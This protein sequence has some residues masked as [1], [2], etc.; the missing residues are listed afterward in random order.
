MVAPA[1]RISKYQP[2][3]ICSQQ[4]TRQQTWSLRFIC[5][6]SS[7]EK[8]VNLT[9]FR[10]LPKQNSP[11]RCL[12][13]ESWEAQVNVCTHLG[14]LITNSDYKWL[15]AL[16]QQPSS[17]SPGPG[18]LCVN[19][20]TLNTSLPCCYDGHR[21]TWPPPVTCQLADVMSKIN[22]VHQFPLLHN[23]TYNI[24]ITHCRLRA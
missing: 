2:G 18:Q 24:H 12:C 20:R 22:Y 1:V 11:S 8:C 21:L 16:P 4:H 13:F 15:T 17:C 6:L 14:C 19:M 5:L 7:R 9:P 10:F 23:Y 3:P